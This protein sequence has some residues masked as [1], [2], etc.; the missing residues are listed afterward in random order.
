M[1]AW[2]VGQ[3]R[4]KEV[5]SEVNLVAFVIYMWLKTLHLW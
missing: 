3:A 5:E 2:E 1:A 4:K